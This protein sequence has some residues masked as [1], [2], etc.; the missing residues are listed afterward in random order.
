MGALFGERVTLA[1]ENGPDVELLVYGDE[2]YARYE[3]PD[4][5][6]VVYDDARGL[7]CYALLREG[8]FASSGV[9]ATAPP[10]PDARRHAKEAPAVRQAKA[11]ARAAARQPPPE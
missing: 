2:F 11:S 3:T 6:P 8:R 9:P 4:R 5:Y 7:F 1:Q 10:P